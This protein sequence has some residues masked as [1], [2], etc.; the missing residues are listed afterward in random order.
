MGDAQIETALQP[1]R[2][3]L[4]AA[5]V[6]VLLAIVFAELEGLQ[7]WYEHRNQSLRDGFLWRA[8]WIL[9]PWLVLAALVP[10]V[11]WLCRR[12]P[13]RRGDWTTP[14]VH[15]LASFVFPVVHLGGLSLLYR[16]I[17]ER[18]PLLARIA[19]MLAFHYM[20]DVIAYWAIAGAF[21]AL[22]YLR[23]DPAEPDAEPSWRTQ[24]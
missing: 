11:V 4:R 15:A 1:W 19:D 16:L 21:F 17:W 13:L 7:F 24:F 6:V 9:P 3:R 8:W 5:G 22:D 14:V 23:A 20:F 18:Q 10:A 12:F 2:R